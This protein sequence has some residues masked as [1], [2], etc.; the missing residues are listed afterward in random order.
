MDSSKPVSNFQIQITSWTEMNSPEH[1]RSQVFC[2]ESTYVIYSSRISSSDWTL[3]SSPSQLAPAP[4]FG[5]KDACLQ[6]SYQGTQVLAWYHSCKTT[7]CPLLKWSVRRWFLSLAFVLLNLI[8]K[9]Q[10]LSLFF[11]WELFGWE[12]FCSRIDRLSLGWIWQ[13]ED[14]I[15]L[16]FDESLLRFQ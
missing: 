16:D 8:H 3:S 5:N 2:S 6:C 9:T 1:H 14:R 11:N 4:L 12:L 13:Q 15:R 7:R 10:L